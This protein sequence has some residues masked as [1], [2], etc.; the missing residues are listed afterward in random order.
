MKKIVSLF[1]VGS[2]AASFAIGA[3]FSKKSN[4]E[5]LNLAKSVKAQDQADL[6]IEMKKRMNE[7]KYKDAK[8]FHQQ[9]RANLHENISKLSTQE[10]NQRRTI[11]QEDMQ[12]LTDEMSGKEIRELNL[13]HYNNAHSHKNHHGLRSHHANCP[14]R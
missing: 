11:V 9:F 4:D 5:I 10:R 14:M 6:V 7:M 13:H 2:L 8:D 1:I 3:D 12:K